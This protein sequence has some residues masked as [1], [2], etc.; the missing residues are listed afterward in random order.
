MKTSIQ[1]ITEINSHGIVSE[2]GKMGVDHVELLAEG[3]SDGNWGNSDS[4][5]RFY[6]IGFRFVADTNGDPVWEENDPLAFDE[7]AEACEVDLW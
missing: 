7:L 5:V 2:C 6:L 4:R 1:P 3:H